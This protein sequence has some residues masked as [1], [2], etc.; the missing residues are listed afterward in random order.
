MTPSRT[1]HWRYRKQTFNKSHRNMRN[2]EQP[3][4]PC[5]NFAKREHRRHS[6]KSEQ[7]KLVNN[8]QCRFHMQQIWSS[9]V[10]TNGERKKS[11]T[12]RSWVYVLLLLLLYRGAC[13]LLGLIQFVS[14]FFIISPWSSLLLLLF[15]LKRH[16]FGFLSISFCVLVSSHLPT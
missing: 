15:S 2:D 1:Q 8:N 13:V 14:S 3:V 12:Q 7:V 16:C 10:G 11:G 6:Q 5:E 4:K 9:S